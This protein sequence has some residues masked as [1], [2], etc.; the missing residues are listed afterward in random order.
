MGVARE[1][2]GAVGDECLTWTHSVERN[3]SVLN[4]GLNVVCGRE[5]YVVR[6]GV[7]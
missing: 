3:L 1:W 7:K 5:Y 6:I 2:S 4:M